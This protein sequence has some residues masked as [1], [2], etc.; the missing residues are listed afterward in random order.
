MQA[1]KR[2]PYPDPLYQE[3][4][5]KRS[6]ENA[7][8]SNAYNITWTDARSLSDFFTIQPARQNKTSLLLLI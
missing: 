4:R 3:G 2:I 6:I 7:N 8:T 5:R 1:T